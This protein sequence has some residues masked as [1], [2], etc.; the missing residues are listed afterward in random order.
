MFCDGKATQIIDM[1]LAEMPRADLWL[2]TD[3]RA[4]SH[5]PD[6]FTATLDRDGARQVVTARQVIV[7]TGGKSIPKMGATGLAYDIARQFGLH[8]SD[9]R[10][11]SKQA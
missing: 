7:A 4:L 1:L 8:V 5:G 10:P 2:R 9:T 3:L 11:A 6:G